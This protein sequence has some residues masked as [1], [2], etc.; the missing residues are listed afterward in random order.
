MIRNPDNLINHK[1]AITPPE[2]QISDALIKDKNIGGA[3]LAASF[4]KKFEEDGNKLTEN[5]KRG[6]KINIILGRQE[7][8]KKGIKVVVGGPPH[9]GKSVFVYALMNNLHAYDTLLLNAAPDGE[10]PWLMAHYGNKEAKKYRQKGDFTAE[11]VNDRARK[12][13]NWVGPLTIVDIGG[14]ITE[15]NKKIIQGA[16]HAIIL[17]G[18]QD[19]RARKSD[20]TK[21]GGMPEDMSPSSFVK[22]TK[23]WKDFFESNG[24]QVIGTIQS[25]LYGKTDHII[26]EKK[27]VLRGS[28][29]SLKRSESA[30][31]RKMIQALAE[32]INDLVRKNKLYE[33]A[34]SPF[35]MP[36]TKFFKG[37]PKKDEANPRTLQRNAIPFLYER[38]LEYTGV[39][40][41]LYGS[42]NSWQSVSSCLALIQAGSS[43]VRTYSQD[44]Y[45]E[46][47]ELQQSK[48]INSEWWEK[49]IYNGVLDGKPV[50]LV[51]HKANSSAG[52]IAKP[53]D[54]EK[55][56]I[57]EMPEN[58]IVIISSGGPNWLKSS[59][60]AGYRGKVDSIALFNPGNG[61]TVVWT[62][63]DKK[64]LGT[65]LF[66]SE[67]D[68]RHHQKGS[69][70]L[71]RYMEAARRNL[72]ATSRTAHGIIDTS[73][74]NT[75]SRAMAE[76][77]S[78]NAA[79]LSM[80]GFE[81]A[82]TTAFSAIR[83]KFKNPMELKMFVEGIAGIVNGG[84]VKEGALIRS[85][86]DSVKYPY[87]RIEDL[88]AAMKDFYGQL[89]SRMNN[90]NNDP[91]ETAAFAEYG[92]DICG[93][94][95]ADG[96]SKTAKVI[97]TFIL[98]RAKHA[99]PDYS[100]GQNRDYAANRAEYY[101]HEPK[102]PKGPHILQDKEAYAEF[103][104]YYRG[105]FKEGE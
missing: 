12:V 72:L 3:A 44:G 78:E 41:Y 17:A 13:K 87:T 95:F 83:H 61:A 23:R 49:P 10:G 22:E 28:V 19:G 14:M 71:K 75:K 47:K 90:E 93:H 53:E 67:Q 98:M 51:R 60:A 81:K 94:F 29:H 20:R 64:M 36:V 37:I 92:I 25:D 99:L 89:L 68:E 7:K 96:C 85:G 32:K 91:V 58:A 40:V 70:V 103:L 86:E 24:L 48:E 46:I 1:R 73:S 18:S 42:L 54:L 102:E 79:K 27:G 74:S 35:V 62:K 80:D 38:A 88:P 97:S 2:Q 8:L 55:T 5:A 82:I 6:R 31:D 56:T 101:S 84:I 43:D 21:A 77:A 30:V 26:G 76:G 4:R 34:Y 100:R 104:K 69:G 65:Q 15:E 105:L 57:P 45:V 16:T 39:P 9:S 66:I 63:E 59:I 11:Y 33:G 50:Y 52:I